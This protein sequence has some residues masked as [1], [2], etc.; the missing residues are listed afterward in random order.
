[1]TPNETATHNNT[2]SESLSARIV[3]PYYPKGR[4][5]LDILRYT[6]TTI[7]TVRFLPLLYVSI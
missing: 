5:L 7:R 1:M 4:L 3:G 6:F 2:F